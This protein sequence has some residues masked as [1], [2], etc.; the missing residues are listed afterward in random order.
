MKDEKIYILG[1]ALD[2]NERRVMTL[3]SEVLEKSRA[4]NRIKEANDLDISDLE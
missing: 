4:L 1:E 3:E 2:A